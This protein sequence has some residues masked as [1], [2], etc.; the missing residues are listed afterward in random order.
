MRRSFRPAGSALAHSRSG[1]RDSRKKRM[2]TSTTPIVRFTASRARSPYPQSQ[3]AGNMKRS[4]AIRAVKKATIATVKTFLCADVSRKPRYHGKT[5][6]S[7]AASAA[8][9]KATATVITVRQGGMGRVALSVRPV[10]KT[11][12]DRRRIAERWAT[13]A[14]R[15]APHPSA[16]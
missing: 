6:T 8:R 9:A 5:A 1:R 16:R 14:R 2:E 4:Q 3:Y 7:H 10:R 11:P 13:S 15:S 12:S